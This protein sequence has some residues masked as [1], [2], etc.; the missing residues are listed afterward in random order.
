[1]NIV[2]AMERISHLTLLLSGLCSLTSCVPQ[3]Q[4]VL[5]TT[6]KTWYEAQSYCRENCLDLAT[7]DDMEEM[8]RLLRDVED[9]YDDGLWIG[10]H[11]G[12]ALLW[13]W[14]LAD[15]DF[16]KEGERSYLVWGGKKHDGEQ[17]V[18]KTTS[19]T[20]TQAR[21]YCRTYHSDLA[22]V[23]NEAESQ[24]ILKVAKG[25]KVWVGLFRDP[26]I[27]SDGTYSSLRHWK[28]DQ[29]IYIKSGTTSC[30]AVLKSESGKNLGAEQ[31]VLSNNM[32][33]W[34]DARDYCRTYHSDLASVRNE[35]ESQIILKV[36]KGLKVWVGLFRDPWIWSDGTYS[37]FRHWRQ[38]ALYLARDRCAAMVKSQSGKW[39]VWQCNAVN[40]FICSCPIVRIVKVKISSQDSVLE[41][42]LDVEDDILKQIKQQLRN[43]SETTHLRLRWKK[44]PDGR[45]FIKEPHQDQ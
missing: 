12:A 8:E 22:S 19:L 45:V 1:M 34:F 24:I 4:Y 7:I 43:V 40:P 17:Y 33:T 37:S 21:D 31:Y 25:L 9:K 6:P 20:W 14:S 26:W 44:S 28:A 29:S 13:Y 35:A 41:H 30:A 3:H 2:A 42:N 36:A 10:L 39:G 18:L 23:R 5:V 32:V 38:G 27:W 11:T 15:K 16:Y